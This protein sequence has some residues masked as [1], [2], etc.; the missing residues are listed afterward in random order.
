MYNLINTLFCNLTQR[1][2]KVMIIH[3]KEG[4]AFKKWTTAT[5]KKH[6]RRFGKKTL[7]KSRPLKPKKESLSYRIFIRAPLTTAEEDMTL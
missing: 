7:D 5:S 2:K 6:R 1:M 3:Y 4:V